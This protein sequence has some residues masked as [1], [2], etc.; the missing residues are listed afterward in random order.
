MH[1]SDL[2]AQL[3]PARRRARSERR[4]SALASSTGRFPA[5]LPLLQAIEGVPRDKLI[6]CTKVGVTL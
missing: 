6:V 3:G 1:C 2:H 4:R 5:M